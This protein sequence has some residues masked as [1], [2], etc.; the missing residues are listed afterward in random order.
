[1]RR[2]VG[3]IV[4]QRK[5]LPFDPCAPEARTARVG[6]P[7]TGRPPPVPP[8]GRP[9]PCRRSISLESLDPWVNIYNY[10]Y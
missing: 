2:S 1:M 5:L 6:P 8:C 9:R 7:M 3:S 10:M 4:N